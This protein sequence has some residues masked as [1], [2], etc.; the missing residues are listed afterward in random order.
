M[1]FAEA[2]ADAAADDV[3]A[4]GAETDDTPY[5]IEKINHHGIFVLV[6]VQ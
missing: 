2:D 3:T 5:C 1:P 4:A 6:C